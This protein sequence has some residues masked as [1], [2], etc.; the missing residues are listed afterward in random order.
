MRPTGGKVTIAD[1]I[2]VSTAATS[3]DYFDTAGYDHAIVEVIHKAATATNSS[4]KWISLQLMEG[5]VTNVSSQ[6]AISGMVGTTN[7]AATAGSF[8]LGVHNDTA[9]CGVVQFSRC[10]TGKPQYLTVMKTAAASHH[11]TCVSC[12]LYRGEVAADSA[13]NANVVNFVDG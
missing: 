9:N 3:S 5:H 10:L 4:A 6:T 7:T 13:A 2:T 11:T 12:S 1:M 8:V